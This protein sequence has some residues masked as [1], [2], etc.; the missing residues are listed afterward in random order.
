MV[1]KTDIYLSGS[2]KLHFWEGISWLPSQNQECVWWSMVNVFSYLKNVSQESHEKDNIRPLPL[3]GNSYRYLKNIFKNA[4]N[5]SA[6]D[7]AS[8][9]RKPNP[10]FWSILPTSIASLYFE[11]QRLEKKDRFFSGAVANDITRTNGEI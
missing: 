5:K 4:F 3:Y 2:V 1:E 7:W 8:F 10:P 11:R 9:C 6:I